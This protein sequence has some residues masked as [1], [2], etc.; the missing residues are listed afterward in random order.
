MSKQQEAPGELEL[1]RAFLNSADLEEGSDEL[2]DAAALRAW[3]VSHG[4]LAPGCEVTEADRV[5]MVELREAIRALIVANSTGRLDASAAALLD[6]YGQAARLALAMTPGGLDL[7]P[8]DDGVEGACSR[9]LAIVF[10]A[11]V[12]G[13]L[14]RLKACERHSCRWVFYDHSKNRSGRWCSMA[15]C[16]NRTKAARFRARRHS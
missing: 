10:V 2:A 4:L 6:R 1:V 15:V 8:A 14:A 5:R 3:L 16:G 12:A 9:L 13:T 11:G 7:R